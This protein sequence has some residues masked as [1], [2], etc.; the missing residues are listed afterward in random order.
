MKYW[1][2]ALTFAVVM[3]GIGYL[4]LYCCEMEFNSNSAGVIISA[5][6]VLVTALVGWQVYNAIEMR[7][8]FEKVE[9]VKKELDKTNSAYEHKI[10]SLEWLVSALHGGLISKDRFN[11]DTAYFLHCL[12]V[13]GCYIK[14]GAKI[15]S[16]PFK[17]SLEE[18]EDTMRIIKE[19]NNSTEILFMGGNK[20]IVREWYQTAINI[21]NT[22]S[23]HLETLKTR[24][25]KVYEDY[26]ILTKDV[27]VT[28]RKSKSRMPQNSCPIYNAIRKVIQKLKRDKRQVD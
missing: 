5:L 27:V 6:G 26:I 4:N 1:V 18:L 2:S 20:D 16:A 14:S 8:M 24:L 7:G 21:I 13:V 11:G 9:N 22:E 23:K 19:R 25:S 3:L 17:R 12:D 15:D 28:P 10:E